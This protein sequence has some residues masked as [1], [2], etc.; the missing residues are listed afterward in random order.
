MRRRSSEKNFRQNTSSDKIDG[1]RSYRTRARF[2]SFS[3]KSAANSTKV[4]FEKAD[5]DGLSLSGSSRNVGSTKLSISSFDIS[6]RRLISF[7]HSKIAASLVRD[8]LY[9]KTEPAGS[10]SPTHWRIW[11]HGNS[12]ELSIVSDDIRLPIGLENVARKFALPMKV[13]FHDVSRDR[14]MRRID[15]ASRNRDES[16]RL[17]VSRKLEHDA[18]RANLAQLKS[19]EHKEVAQSL[20]KRRLRWREKLV[21]SP[22]SIDLMKEDRARLSRLKRE[23]EAHKRF[24]DQKA[25]L[26]NKIEQAALD[27]SIEEVPIEMGLMRHRK[28]DLLL[29]LR[30]LRAIRDVERTNSRIHEIS[31]NRA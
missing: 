30:Q 22:L 15:I 17:R 6:S 9:V 11:N 5:E 13:S 24:V 1:T 23:E 3:N 4:G 28:R 19:I 29:Q 31:L 8:I 2:G 12:S 26:D 7:A 10:D 25:K 21:S 16:L 20:M 18:V 14:F 27:A